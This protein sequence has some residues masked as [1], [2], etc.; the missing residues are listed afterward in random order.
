MKHSFLRIVICLLTGFSF[1]I[2]A[3][4]VS[5]SGFITDRFTGAALPDVNI[6]LEKTGQGTASRQNGF[7]EIEMQAGQYR[8]EAS[9][10]GYKPV[11]KPVDL[12]SDAR[13]SFE[14]E[15]QPVQMNHVCV[16]ATRTNHFQS[17]VSVSSEVIPVSDQ[18]GSTV[19]EQLHSV[20]GLTIK[21]YG[22]LAGVSSP[23]LRGTS[24]DQVLIMLDGIRLNTA[25]GT[26]VSLNNFPSDAFDRIEIVR[27]GHSALLGSNALGGVINLISKSTGPMSKPLYGIQTT[28]G[29]WGTVVTSLYHAR[30]LGPLQIHASYN[31]SVSD[32]NF[33]YTNPETGNKETRLNNDFTSDNFFLNGHVMFN[34]EHRLQF[35]VH[36]LNSEMGSPGPLYFGQSL[37]RL[38]NRRDIFTLKSQNQI[39]K[40]I[41]LNTQIY[42]HQMDRK[43]RDPDPMWGTSDHHENIASGLEVQAQWIVSGNLSLVTGAEL[44]QDDIE[45]TQ[46]T[47][48]SRSGKSIY[49]QSEI[50]RDFQVWG[51]MAR[52][53]LVPALRRDDLSDTEAQSSP[54]IG[55]MI[56]FGDR[57]QVS[58]RANLGK[59]FRAPTFDHLYWF[60]PV[61]QM[62]GN[63]DLKP[64]KATNMDA[65]I[66]IQHSDFSNL[67]YEMT[68]FKNDID[69]LID[70]ADTG[71]WIYQV[72]NVQEARISGLETQVHFVTADNLFTMKMGHTWLK[73]ADRTTGLYLPNRPANMV[74]VQ[75]G[76]DRSFFQ[77]NITYEMTGIRYAD[78]SNTNPMPEYML[79][80]A[81][82][83]FRMRLDPVR[84]RLTLQGLNLWN[85]DYSNMAGYPMPGREFRATLTVE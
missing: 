44:R 10:I 77:A 47:S 71:N 38:K 60:D 51:T 68:Y 9:I 21:N 18:H 72:R 12:T 37:S 76:M 63:P 54:K 85:T 81:G 27:G 70:W 69:N 48:R 82:A 7:Y 14:L 23:T 42:R 35:I 78:A 43:Y 40:N 65:G 39:M 66:T 13:I 1:S 5:V 4:T 8:I 6:V 24:D 28:V 67:K 61:Y 50:S 62:Y 80:H 17:Q 20:T 57:M 58:V 73:A 29:S 64:E 83:G 36:L 16:T 25:Q 22:S 33:S 55:Y 3:Q 15:P 19:G 30:H 41:H 46:Y 34:Q 2:H 56:A 53:K 59:S 84:I 52:M 75:L 31:R 74:H 45:T 11:I 49:V 26:P 32:G 79:V